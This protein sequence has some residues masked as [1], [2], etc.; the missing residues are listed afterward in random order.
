MATLNFSVDEA[1]HILRANKFLPEAIRDVRPDIDGLLVTIPGGIE[2]AV[3]RESFAN[4]ILRLSYSSAS[5]AFKFADKLGKV[6]AAID[7]FIR[8]YPFFRREG[9]SF[10]LDLNRALQTRAAGIQVKNFELRDG[11]IKVEI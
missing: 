3:R 6:D 8:P 1:L 9:K 2:I 4:G 10:I 11:S 7:N 5:W